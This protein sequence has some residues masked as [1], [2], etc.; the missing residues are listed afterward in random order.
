MITALAGGVG[1]ARLLAR[2]GG[3]GGAG[4]HHRRR[5][6]RRR[7]RA[8]R[9]AHLARPRHRDVHA[10][11]C[12]QPRHRVGT[13]RRDVAG[14]GVLA[15]PRGLDLVQP[16]GPGPRHPLLPHPTAARG[17]HA[18]PGHR[19]AG[20][21]VRGGRPPGAGDR[22]PA[23]YPGASWP[24]APRSGSRSTSYASAT[25]SRWPGSAS[26]G[27]SAPAPAR[28]C[29]RRSTRP[30]PSWCAPPTRWCPSTRCCRSRECSTSPPPPRPGGR[31]L[32]DRGRR[33]AEGPGRPAPARDG[34]RVV[35]RW[36]WPARY[37][38]WVGTLVIDEADAGLSDEVEAEGVRCVVA[39]T[40]MSSRGPRR[41]PGPDRARCPRLSPARPGR[42]SHRVGSPSIPSP[43]WVT[44][45]PA[46]TS[47][48]CWPTLTPPGAADPGQRAW[49]TGMSS[50][51][52]RRW[53]PRPRAAWSSSTPTTRAAKARL[54]EAESVR[55]VRRRGDLV[56]S[57]TP[58]GFICANAGV[59]LSNVAPGRPPSC[60]VDPDRSARRIRAGLR[61]R[62][63][64]L[65]RGGDIGHLR[66]PLAERG[67]RRGH[68]LS[69][70]SPASSTC[71]A[72]PMPTA[73][74]WT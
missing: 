52:P 6:H 14:H 11:R 48:P 26:T 56:I 51:S 33:G 69:P 32:T 55:V 2:D 10:G 22:R 71:A 42:P 43:G 60:R 21:L 63:G 47:A 67:D 8:A 16:R 57:E 38:P 24:T 44:W 59:D 3:G 54:I 73:A 19:R 35:G 40:V 45:S 68:R 36:A 30:R 17:G 58:H 28:A 5:Q 7:H 61:R 4:G 18:G 12:H 25:T 37:A 50:S 64:R 65:G 15:T 41:R 39:P 23:P 1:A 62:P 13:G 53:C 31:G 20:P 9:T 74:G 70:G 49:S 27:P 72:P 66:T 46:T 34:L 29:S